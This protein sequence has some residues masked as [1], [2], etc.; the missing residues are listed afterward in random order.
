MSE[1]KN[2]SKDKAKDG[3]TNRRGLDAIANL[4]GGLTGKA[5][6]AIRKRKQKNKPKDY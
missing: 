1:Y 5:T 4:F 6:K 2:K 3:Y